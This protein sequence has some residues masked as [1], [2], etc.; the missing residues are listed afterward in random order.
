VSW[1]NVVAGQRVP[2]ELTSLGRAWLAAADE[3][4]RQ[5]LLAHFKARRGPEWDDL[6]REIAQAVASVRDT[7][8]CWASWQPQVV[9]LATPVTLQGHPVHVL[10]MSI[11]GDEAAAAVVARLH[12]PLLALA[13][14]L[15]ERITAA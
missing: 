15:Q 9:A 4:V 8:Y 14:Q 5:R 12:E 3:P 13:K 2:M 6:S 11:T 1:R 7:G 10:N